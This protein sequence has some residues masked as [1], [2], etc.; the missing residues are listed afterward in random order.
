MFSCE[1]QYMCDISCLGK[2]DDI[3]YNYLTMPHFTVRIDNLVSHTLK[4][5]SGQ[6]A[7]LHLCSVNLQDFFYRLYCL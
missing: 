6:I 4:M 7:M 5:I 1:L 2:T 3:S